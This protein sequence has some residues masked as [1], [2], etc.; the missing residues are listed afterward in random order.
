[1]AQRGAR[2]GSGKLSTNA[3]AVRTVPS[4]WRKRLAGP[5][6]RSQYRPRNW[7]QIDM[8]CSSGWTGTAVSTYAG[9]K[10]HR[11]DGRL[12]SKD[13]SRTLPPPATGAAHPQTPRPVPVAVP[14]PALCSTVQDPT[15][16]DC[17]NETGWCAPLTRS[18]R[19]STHTAQ[20]RPGS[21]CGARWLGASVSGRSYTGAGD[22]GARAGSHGSSSGGRAFAVGTRSRCHRRRGTARP[23]R[24]FHDS[25]S[26][27]VH[28]MGCISVVVYQLSH[29]ST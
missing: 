15:H 6:R 26:L 13:L 18:G 8:N 22:R 16:H 23:H 20:R 5:G 25:P 21:A 24:L 4:R 19:R 11:Y 14:A 3:S 12:Y 10:S 9:G 17:Q 28:L 29:P 2:T 1:M 27:F 7:P